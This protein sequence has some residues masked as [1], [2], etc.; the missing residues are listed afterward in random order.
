MSNLNHLIPPSWHHGNPC[1][2]K[3]NL[4]SF[5]GPNDILTLE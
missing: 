1:D 3:W 2:L 5:N 4:W